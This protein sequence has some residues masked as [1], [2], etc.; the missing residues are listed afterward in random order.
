[1]K[2]LVFLIFAIV[3]TGGAAHAQSTNSDQPRSVKVT[4]LTGT[5]DDERQR[6]GQKACVNQF[7]GS[8][9]RPG[10]AGG[11]AIFLGKMLP[12]SDMVENKTIFAP[13]FTLN[14]G[15][16]FRYHQIKCRDLSAILPSSET[17]GLFQAPDDWSSQRL[18]G[19]QLGLTTLAFSELPSLKPLNAANLVTATFTHDWEIVHWSN[20]NDIASRQTILLGVGF[21]VGAGSGK[22][23][24]N[25]ATVDS[26]VYAV[27]GIVDVEAVF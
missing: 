15:F 3:S 21:L 16:R 23:E 2:F 12:K 9:L 8:D 22:F 18:F 19:F 7:Y 11:G 10:I 13:A 14:V 17:E 27:G 26:G 4:Y 20:P 5:V 1:M 6:L 24:V 25:G